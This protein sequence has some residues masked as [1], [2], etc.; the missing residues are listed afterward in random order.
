MDKLA[1]NLKRLENKVDCLNEAV[2]GIHNQ[3]G[4]LISEKENTPEASAKSS[5]SSSTLPESVL[6]SSEEGYAFPSLKD[7]RGY[8]GWWQRR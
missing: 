4:W 5:S 7:Y 2:E 3:I 1:Q 6:S 8:Y